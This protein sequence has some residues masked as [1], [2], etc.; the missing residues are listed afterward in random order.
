MAAIEQTL[1]LHENELR[2]MNGLRMY[3]RA[4]NADSSGG[5]LVFYSRRGSGPYYRWSYEEKL[6]AW[7]SARMH[8]DDLSLEELCAASWKGVPPTLQV[9]LG[10][11][12]LE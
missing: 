1:L 6:G 10:E 5:G 4:M 3:T 7:C 2:K 9:R 11:H 12:Y 8:A